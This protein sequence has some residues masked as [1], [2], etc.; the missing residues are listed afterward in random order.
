MPIKF[1]M[2]QSYMSI[3][4]KVLVKEIVI[5][6]D[7]KNFVVPQ[8]YRYIKENEYIYEKLKEGR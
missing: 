2:E 7:E 5:K 4:E 3:E 1:L 8:F 6:K